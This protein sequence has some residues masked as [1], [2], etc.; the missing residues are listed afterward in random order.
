MFN[1]VDNDFKATIINT[2]KELKESVFKELRH[3]MVTKPSLIDTTKEREIFINIY[4][5]FFFSFF[6]FEQEKQM[7]NFG[8]EKYNS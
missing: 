2:L 5:T 8:I 6:Y 3:I 7:E 1:L 4:F